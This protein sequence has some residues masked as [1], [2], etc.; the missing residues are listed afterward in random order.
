MLYKIVL[1]D[2]R[3]IAPIN[4]VSKFGPIPCPMD[5]LY[6]NWGRGNYIR[7]QKNKNNEPN[8]KINIMDPG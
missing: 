8:V 5:T 2:I 3:C 7:N 4:L 1:D 6:G